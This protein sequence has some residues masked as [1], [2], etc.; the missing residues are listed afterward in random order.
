[1]SLE[2]YRASIISEIR[3]IAH[4]LVGMGS[5][6]EYDQSWAERLVTLGHIRDAAAKINALNNKLAAV[7]DEL[8][9]LSMTTR[10]K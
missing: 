4:D 2:N 3:E 10:A 8:A 7:D 1:M 5:Q 9:A 6:L